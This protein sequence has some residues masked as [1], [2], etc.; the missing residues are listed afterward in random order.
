MIHYELFIGSLYFNK[1]CMDSTDVTGDYV[2]MYTC[3]MIQFASRILKSSLLLGLLAKI[4][5][6]GVLP[7]H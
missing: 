1:R 6:L 7:A 2:C 4:K 3:L 5:V